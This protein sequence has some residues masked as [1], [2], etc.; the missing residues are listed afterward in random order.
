MGLNIGVW[1]IF[2][3]Q[4]SCYNHSRAGHGKESHAPQREDKRTA[5]SSKSHKEHT[6]GS[7]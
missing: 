2:K 4:H 3:V 1:V 5:P 6:V 7:A